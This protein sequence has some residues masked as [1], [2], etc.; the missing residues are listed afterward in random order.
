METKKIKMIF[1][2][3]LLL[4][5]GDFACADDRDNNC[6]IF[7]DYNPKLSIA[8]LDNASVAECS[9]R[10]K[11]HIKINFSEFSHFSSDS[12]TFVFVHEM[13]A[14]LLRKFENQFDRANDEK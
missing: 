12:K 13:D 8:Y 2:V 9:R 7:W 11:N 6:I 3:L 1:L 14:D 4:V 10:Y 5:A